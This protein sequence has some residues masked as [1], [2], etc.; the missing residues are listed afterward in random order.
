MGCRLVGGIASGEVW[1]G[2]SEGGDVS[3]SGTDGEDDVSETGGEEEDLGGPMICL[4]FF[5]CVFFFQAED[6]IRDVRT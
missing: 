6:G 3:D 4:F 1:H 2:C 5:F